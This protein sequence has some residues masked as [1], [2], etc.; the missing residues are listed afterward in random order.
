MSYP[1]LAMVKAVYAAMVDG[2]TEILAEA[3]MELTESFYSGM[4]RLR[5]RYAP[6]TSVDSLIQISPNFPIS[7]I[8]SLL[9]SDP[10]GLAAFC[11]RA[12]YI[13]RAIVA[14]TVPAGYERVRI[15]LH[16]GNTHAQIDGLVNALGQWFEQERPKDKAQSQMMAARL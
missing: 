8:I 3:L 4:A 6:T 1:A 10:K 13:V 9:T 2:H 11:Q 5:G 12:G 7:P 16:A 14:P 15:C